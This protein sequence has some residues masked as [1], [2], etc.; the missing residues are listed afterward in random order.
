MTRKEGF[1]SPEY[2]DTDDK[3]DLSPKH[4]TAYHKISQM[5]IKNNR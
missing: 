4:D 1:V 3:E 2:P 5:T